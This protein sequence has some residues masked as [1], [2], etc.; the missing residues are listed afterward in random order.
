MGG[1]AEPSGA[2]IP[3]PIPDNFMFFDEEVSCGGSG[4]EGL[5]MKIRSNPINVRERSTQS[6]RLWDAAIS[7]DHFGCSSPD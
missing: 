7:L 5:T 1:V 4:V 2:E 3:G 6:S